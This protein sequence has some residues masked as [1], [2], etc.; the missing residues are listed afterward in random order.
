MSTAL[1]TVRQWW[2]RRGH[3]RFY[4]SQADRDNP[5]A[6]NAGTA[7]RFET[8]V[9]EL[10]GLLRPSAEDRVLDLGGGNG[11][12]SRR[13]FSGCRQLVVSDICPTPLQEAGVP[14][15]TASFVVADMARPP[16]RHGSFTTLFSYS[17]LPHVGSEAVLRRMV[18]AWDALLAD[19]G[20]L[21]IGDI[22]DR[23]R[24]PVIA[25]RGFRKA[26]PMEGLKYFA[27]ISLISYFSR[28][29]LRRMLLDQGYGVTILNQASHR[30]FY[31]ERFDLMA[32][33]PG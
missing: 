25:A 22:P 32:R 5:Y 20:T 23:R 12:L 27:A 11:V 18:Q 3:R 16:F 15:A 14:Q 28:E 7:E 26:F 21:F 10:Q 24:L 9:A 31:L 2:W 33:K 4:G 1:S 29:R 8:L 19:G 6:L 30:R 17:T 13:V